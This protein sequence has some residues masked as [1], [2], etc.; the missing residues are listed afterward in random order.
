MFRNFLVVALRNLFRNRLYSITN[1]LGL[2]IGIACSILILLWVFDELSYDRFHHNSN[3]L[4]QVMVKTTFDGKIHTWNSLP[5]PTYKALQTEHSNIIHTAIRDRGGEHLLTVGEKKIIMNGMAVSEQFLDMFQFPLIYGNASNILDDIS[6]I[7]ITESTAKA[8]FGEEDAMNQIILIDDKREMK[9]AGILKDIPNNSSLE[10]DFLIPWGNKLQDVPWIKDIADKWIGYSMPVYVELNDA[11]R[12]ADVENGIKNLL[13]DHGM[14][15]MQPE[16]FLYPMARWRLYSTFVDG[17]E[18]GG[19]NDYVQLFSLIAVF[20]LVIACINFINLST[21]RSENRA[22]E[23]GIRKSVGSSRYN[24]IVQF[25]SESMILSIIAYIIALLMTQ[26][27]LPLYNNL[28]EKQLFIDF[29]SWSFWVFSIIIILITGIISGSYPAFYL[30]S[31]KPVKVLKGNIQLGRNATLPRKVLVTVQFS[32]SIFL[33]ISAIIIFSQIQHLKNR[34]LGYEQANLITVELNDELKANYRVI[35]D[36]LL[37]TGEVEAVTISDSPIT[38]IYNNSFMEWPG[39]PEDIMVAFAGITCDYD[40]TRTM[41]IKILEGRDFSKDFGSDSTAIIVN[42]AGLEAMNLEDPIGTELVLN[43][44]R[45]NLVG[46]ADNVLMESPYHEVRPLYMVMGELN[47]FLSLRIKETDDLQA[48]LKIIENVFIEYN[49]AYPFEYTFADI[50]FNEK[51]KT[52]NMTQR[53]ANL[54]TLLTIIITGLG[55]FGLAAY[56]TEQRTKEIGIRKVMGATVLGII[57]L[58]SKDISRLVI[59][60]FGLSAPLA[61]WLLNTYLDRYPIRMD[62]PFWIFPLTGLVALIFALS[63]VISQVLRAAHTN[64]AISLRDE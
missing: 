26:L 64:P 55:L 56:T 46:I 41:G 14:E 8:L 29:Q 12:K 37:K 19:L 62:I 52:I 23:V 25:I 31:F 13:K 53:L 43:G 44:K 35:K 47:G 28:V 6:S 38:R 34:H 45:R 50:E 61:W 54:F 4:Y 27:V 20:I 57:A 15:D 17:V 63:I 60:A 21:A 24:I 58:I 10:F 33:I 51:F 39:K 11:S 16:L 5:L 30:S 7:I 2:S 49:S 18:K 32:F 48:S 36:E 22:K 59:I 42:K 3:H 1:V 40:Y 9:V